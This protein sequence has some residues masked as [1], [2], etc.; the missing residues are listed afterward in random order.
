MIVSVR[1]IFKLYKEE[2]N[3]ASIIQKKN[4]LGYQMVMLR[5]L[6]VLVREVVMKI[7]YPQWVHV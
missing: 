4:N 7:G 6:N 3:Y 5:P 2:Q 1:L